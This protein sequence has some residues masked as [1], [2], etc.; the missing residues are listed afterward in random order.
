M[1]R[2]LSGGV[3]AAA[4][5]GQPFTINIAF[6][7]WLCHIP[8]MARHLRVEFPGAIYHVTCRMV[9]DWRT[10]KTFLFKDE[11]DHERF[12]DR[13]AE[14]VEQYNI[15][16][17]LFVCMANHFHLV[18]ETPEAN[19]S[20]FMQSLCTA[21]TVYYNLRHGRHGHLLDGRYKAK[22]VEGDDY[23]LALSRY[24]HLNP[25]CISSMKRKPIEER[26]KAL[27]AHRWSSYPS[28]IGRRKALDFVEYGPLLAEMQGK[29]S[30]RGLAS[31][32]R[33]RPKRYREFVEAGLAE[34]DDDVK[35]ALKESPRSIGSDGFRAR[36]DELYQKRLET[37][38]RP[39]DVSF[40]HITE[41]LPPG[42]IL[43]VLADVFAVEE[44]E[45]SLRSRGS[46][47]RAVAS[48][49]LIRYAGLTQRD[50]AD[51]LGIGSG[52]AV[53]NQLRR[54]PDKLAASRRLRKQVK[55]SEVR[56]DKHKLSRYADEEAP[57]KC[58]V[59]G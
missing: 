44:S 53:C 50:V 34:S 51:L 48:K 30:I 28:Y 22:V 33:E 52:A 46:A 42:D 38:A 57:I 59:K 47:L 20:K 39:E 3:L 27:R 29:S 16:L 54:L 18:F 43:A 1:T 8:C 40:R 17:Y 9:G 45:F 23:L 56:L 55:E 21:Y 58:I 4:D 41:P 31:G 11:A 6:N 25:V 14:R 15:R 2:S 26:I 36:I 32:R 24:V 7:E 37:H 13:L 5:W 35:V 12:L 10:E 19:C 49:L